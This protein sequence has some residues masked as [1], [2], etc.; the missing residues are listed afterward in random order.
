MS[1]LRGTELSDTVRASVRCSE[2][3]GSAQKFRSGNFLM[4]LEGSLL[5]K[6]QGLE[7]IAENKPVSLTIPRLAES[8]LLSFAL[9]LRAG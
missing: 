6:E 4:N 9:R 1:N 8:D 3:G 2:R 5:S 7:S